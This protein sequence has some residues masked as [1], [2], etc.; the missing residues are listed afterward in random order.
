VLRNDNQRRVKSGADLWSLA[1]RHRRGGGAG[2]GAE[3][4]QCRVASRSD[5]F[6]DLGG[7]SMMMMMVLFRVGE[8]LGVE[9]PQGVL[10]EVPCLKEFC[11][12]IDQHR[13]G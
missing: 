4:L 8:E 7:D 12:L 13:R 6:F 5:N 1:N 11:E 9:L 3:I 2:V 10:V